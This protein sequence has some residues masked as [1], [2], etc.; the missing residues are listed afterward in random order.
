[1]Q[2]IRPKQFRAQLLPTILT[3]PVVADA[4]GIPRY[5][6]TIWIDFLHGDL[7][8]QTRY[9]Y[10]QAAAAL[11]D[12]AEHCVDDFNDKF[13]TFG[14]LESDA[15]EVFFDGASARIAFPS[16]MQDQISLLK[17]VAADLIV[18]RS[19][20]TAAS[21]FSALRSVDES[22]LLDVLRSI[23]EDD[24][25][26]FL[27][28]W[29][30]RYHRALEM[31]SARAI[32]YILH[33]AC[34]WNYGAW[35]KAESALVRALPGYSF[36]KYK[37][38]QEDSCFVPIL[39]QSQIV[40]FI[41]EVARQARQRKVSRDEL[42]HT[43]ILA[44]AFQYGL[45]RGQIAR[46]GIDDVV[47]NSEK[48]VHIRVRLLKQR[49]QARARTVVRSVQ[50]GWTPIF[51]ALLQDPAGGAG[52]KFFGKRPYEISDLVKRLA[53][54]LTGSAYST[55]D[56]RHTA[57]QRLVDSGASREEVTDFLGHSDHTAA[58]V[59][60]AA[61][62]KQA[63]LVD[64]ALGKSTIYG[65]IAEVARTKS[66]SVIDLASRPD[67][68][69]ITG[70]PHGI[71]ISGIGAC[72][73]GQ[74]LCQRNPVVACYTCHKFL[75]VEDPSLHQQVLSDLQSVVGQFDQPT[76][77]DRVSPAMLQLRTTLEA[78]SAVVSQM[79]QVAQ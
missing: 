40:D 58:D 56:F 73:A 39:A 29:V 8:S 31:R 28:K 63:D 42:I 32:R 54:E 66:I 65:K 15:W 41:D 7:A 67:D 25:S 18:S 34:K 69:Q 14:E 53:A 27:G 5:A 9:E 20:R 60:F 78:V 22:T 71:P 52:E 35:H 55:R 57:A 51:L 45:R 23:G 21:Y 79:A 62:P 76:R 44:L 3:G 19:A 2:F 75:A 6:A 47:S 50:D 33:C 36:S 24:P 38:A 61:S 4:L 70:M 12:Q 46:L 1:M 30:S 48:I 26:A 16:S 49:G 43:A 74:S 68:E 17:A 64:A 37:S 13:H 59:Y 11:Y 77:I 10:R 72:A